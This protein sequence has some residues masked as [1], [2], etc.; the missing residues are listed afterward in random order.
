MTARVV[1]M[2]TESFH[3]DEENRPLRESRTPSEFLK[4]GDI[5]HKKCPYQGS[6]QFHEKP[7]NV[8][9]LRQTSAHWDEITDALAVL[10]GG[11]SDARKL[12]DAPELMDLWRISQLGSALPWWFILRDEPLPAYAAALSKATLGVGIWAQ[13]MLMRSLVGAWTEPVFTAAN[14]MESVEETGTL[15]GTREVCAGSDKMLMKFFETYL[16]GSPGTGTLVESRAAVLRFGAH[17]ANFKLVMW[18]YFLARRYLYFDAGGTTDLLSRGAE[19]PDFF[20]LEPQ[21]AAAIPPEMRKLWFAGKLAGLVIPFAGDDSDAM[22]AS[23]ALRIADAMGVRAAPATTFATLDQIFLD[24][25]RQ[26]EAGLG[27]DPATITTEITDMLIASGTR[28][29]FANA[30]AG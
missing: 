5:E 10:R 23:A 3:R 30:A 27:G 7:M 21:N 8:G 9:A 25:V 18:L 11:Y 14:I 19:P 16:D 17:Y 2:V 1:R 24:V 12:G 28:A 29:F 6:R 15:I 26:T 22:F 4:P 20:I 13:Q